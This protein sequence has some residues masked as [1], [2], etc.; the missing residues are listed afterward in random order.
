M[1]DTYVQTTMHLTQTECRALV[2]AI[3]ARYHT[4]YC[5]HRDNFGDHNQQARVTELGALV[6]MLS[7]LMTNEEW[8]AFDARG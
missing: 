3:K 6:G 2:G 7:R 5:E 1:T 4:L 8:A